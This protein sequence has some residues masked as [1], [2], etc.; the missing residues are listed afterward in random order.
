[1]GSV[2]VIKQ[3]RYGVFE[4][5]SSSTH[6]ISLSGDGLEALIMSVTNSFPGFPHLQK[7][8]KE[9]HFNVDGYEFGWEIDT[10]N[11]A[12]TKLAYA[13]IDAHGNDKLVEKVCNAFKAITGVT[14]V[15]VWGDAETDKD[16]YKTF[17]ID[18]QS[19]GTAN[20]L[21]QEQ[22]V[23]FIFNPNSILSTDNDNH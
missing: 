14:L 7:E 23:N 21:T 2:V 13:L 6:S 19:S 4:T 11:D 20:E 9:Y 18:H 16:Y 22:M 5:N 17:Y 1:M 12:P 8:D 15:P 3:T 10:Y